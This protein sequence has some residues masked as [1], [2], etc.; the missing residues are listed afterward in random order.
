[1][2]VVLALAV[3]VW[4]NPLRWPLMVNTELTGEWRGKGSS[5]I[6]RLYEDGLF[7]ITWNG[8]ARD[9]MYKGKWKKQADKILLEYNGKRL[10]RVGDSLVIE[11][12]QLIP[13]NGYD[14]IWLK[15]VVFNLKDKN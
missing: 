4:I 6:L 3:F 13:L 12:N 11:N 1:M 8:W 15:A 2:L 9:G 10:D 7:E 5:G 14:D